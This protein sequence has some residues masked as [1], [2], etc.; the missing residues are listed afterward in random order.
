L[1]LFALVAGLVLPRLTTLYESMRWASERDEVLENIANLGFMAFQEGRN[2][3][4]PASEPDEELF[5]RFESAPLNLPQGW[6][7]TTEEPIRYSDNGICSGGR[8]KLE[9]E[10]RTLDV[11][12]RPPLCRPEV[13]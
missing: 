12:L 9:Y 13:L 7:L 8:L 10:G 11:L 4:I 5:S 2:F 3:E 1:A 6:C